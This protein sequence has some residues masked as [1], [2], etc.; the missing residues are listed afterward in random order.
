VR[1]VLRQRELFARIGRW[2]LV[3]ASGLVVNSIAMAAITAAGV[4]Y[5][6]A[7]V[8]ATEVS[9][10][11][12]FVG[13][14]WWAFSGLGSKGRFRRFMAF[15]L[16]NNAALAVRG[17]VIWVLTEVGH[18][19]PT[20]SN[21]LSLVVVMAVRFA[22]ADNLIWERQRRTNQAVSVQVQEI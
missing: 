8:A 10:T 11:W 2:G 14:E 7:A 16:M 6:L 9:T 4:P 17:P 18:L 12:N 20:V 21:A 5:L 15:F 1:S 22:V 13:S 3:G 19:H